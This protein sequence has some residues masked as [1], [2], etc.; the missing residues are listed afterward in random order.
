MLKDIQYGVIEITVRDG[1]IKFL[2]V[3]HT[4]DLEKGI[5]NGHAKD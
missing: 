1:K 3:K 2:A 5:S 4:F